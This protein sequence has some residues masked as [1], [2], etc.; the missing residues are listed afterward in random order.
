MSLS[1][2]C[3]FHFT[4]LKNLKFILE[5]R[6]F[7][8]RYCEESSSGDDSDNSFWWI[9]MVSFCDIRLTQ[10]KEHVEVYGKYALGLS[11]GWG[12]KNK[13]N[14]VFYWT[15]QCS[16]ESIYSELFSRLFKSEDIGKFQDILRY[17]KPYQGYWYKNPK[18][19][20]EKN[21][22]QKTFYDE[23]E[24]RYAPCKHTTG[25]GLILNADAPLKEVEDENKKIVDLGLWFSPENIKY[26]MVEKEAEVKDIVDVILK[27]DLNEDDKINLIR[28]IVVYKEIKDDF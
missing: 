24:W 21:E 17:V 27:I 20:Y 19:K 12:V 4:T 22:E 5:S 15:T 3:L 2:S 16:L 6:K 13:I 9:P 14:P 28:R 25:K 7:L 26:I 8:P 18:G 11:K 23:R 10:V 1:A